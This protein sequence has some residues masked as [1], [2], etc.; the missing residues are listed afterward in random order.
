LAPDTEL[1]P[2]R[3]V[4]STCTRD[5]DSPRSW[6]SVTNVGYRPTFGGTDLSIE[7]F[8]LRP[9]E[10][11]DPIRLSVEFWRRLRDEKKFPTPQDL[12][13]QILRDVGATEK[14]FRRLR[15]HAQARRS[16]EVVS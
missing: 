11:P 9:L 1:L 8:L 10:G 3:G 15:R 16:K 12:R 2:A 4:Y 6:P 13:Q 5:L 7:T 14:F